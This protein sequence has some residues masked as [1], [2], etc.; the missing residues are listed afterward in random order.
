MFQNVSMCLTFDP[1]VIL[2]EINSKEI[3]RQ[4]NKEEKY[5]II[6]ND[7]NDLQQ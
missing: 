4:E 7:E 3:I 1:A 2:L 6:Y 5:C